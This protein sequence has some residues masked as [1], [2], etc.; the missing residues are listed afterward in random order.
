MVATVTQ[1]IPDFTMSSTK[2]TRNVFRDRNREGE[3]VDTRI[4]GVV[5][6]F[7]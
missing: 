7:K 1:E 5:R 3:G 4:E 6:W 2:T